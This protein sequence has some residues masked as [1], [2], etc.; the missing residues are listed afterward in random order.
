[1]RTQ[2]IDA[3]AGIAGGISLKIV[4]LREMEGFSYKE[5]ADLARGAISTVVSRPALRA[6]SFCKSGCGNQ[7]QSREINDELP[8]G[9]PRSL[10]ASPNGE[11]E[12]AA[13]PEL[14]QHLQSC[15]ASRL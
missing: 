1:M 4:I 9:Q 12:A 3:I 5:I 11:L 13:I 14:E 2:C 7:I 8:A 15:A 6:R 10:M